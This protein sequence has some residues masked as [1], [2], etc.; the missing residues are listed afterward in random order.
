MNLPR[1]TL[2]VQ[3]LKLLSFHRRG[4]GF[5]TWYLVKKLRSHKSCV[6]KK[7]V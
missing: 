2:A 1:I 4:C 3:W 6:T 5:N 7:K